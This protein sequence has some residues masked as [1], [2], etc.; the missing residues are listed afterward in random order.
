MSNLLCFF[1]KS[2]LEELEKKDSYSKA[3]KIVERLFKE[4]TD[5]GGNPYL[6]HLYYVSNK[7]EDLNMKTVGLLHD[8]LEDTN[9]TA[10][11]LKQM[12]FTDEIIE[13][14]IIITK[15]GNDLYDEYINKILESHNLI[16]IS[17]K[18]VDMEHNLDISRIKKPTKK[19]L[20]RLEKKYKPNYEKIINYLNKRKGE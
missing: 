9:I 19:D 4:K 6:E 17:V 10:S 5:K 2:E 16:A 13:A 8:L 11:D 18:A 15:D 1:S 7:L 20:E 12:G 3:E 14:L